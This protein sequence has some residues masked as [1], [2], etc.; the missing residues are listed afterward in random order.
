MQVEAPLLISHLT[1]K[2]TQLYLVINQITVYKRV[3]QW[4]DVT[5]VL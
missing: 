5:L 2:Y 3:S 4:A 1:P